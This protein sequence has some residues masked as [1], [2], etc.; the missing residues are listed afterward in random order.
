M[1]VLITGEQRQAILLDG[2]PLGDVNKFKCL[3]SVLITNG[4]GTEEIGS[5]INLAR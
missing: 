2:D 1:T 4:H 5:R 3:R